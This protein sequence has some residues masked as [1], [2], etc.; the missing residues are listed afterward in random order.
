MPRKDS[1]IPI[2]DVYSPRDIRSSPRDGH[3]SPKAGHNAPRDVHDAHKDVHSP[4]KDTHG[5]HKDGHNS[6]KDDHHAHRT[7]YDHKASNSSSDHAHDAAHNDD[8]TRTKT[9]EE[10]DATRSKVDKGEDNEQSAQTSNNQEKSEALIGHGEFF[11][12][13]GDG[14][15]WPSD[16]YKGF[17]ALGFSFFISL[18]AAVVICSMSYPS[19]PASHWF[20]D[21]FFRIYVNGLHKAKHGSDS[22]SFNR[23]GTFD[24][25]NF[26][27]FWNEHTDAPHTEITPVQ[28]YHA[29]AARRLAFDFYGTLAAI[30]EWFT[31]WLLLGYSSFRFNFDLWTEKSRE[32]LDAAAQEKQGT[33]TFPETIK[34][35]IKATKAAFAMACSDGNVKKE[36]VKSLY[37]GTLF[38]TTMNREA[39]AG[40]ECARAWRR[41]HEKSQAKKRVQLSRG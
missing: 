2:K 4:H 33:L 9:N 12:A 1:Q 37:N 20:P 15:F 3:S 5:S 14:V 41:E 8:Q 11:D 27:Q 22:G 31:T 28:L 30:F 16:T 35:T 39:D 32:F 7:H 29:V 25:A 36:D 10:N 18:F 17:R 24:Q 6:H 19:L 38:Y 23:D 13:D 26:D 40:N 21:P 34:P